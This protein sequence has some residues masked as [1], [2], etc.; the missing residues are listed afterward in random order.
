MSVTKL[1]FLFLTVS[2]GMTSLLL[3]QQLPQQSAS[4][5]PAIVDND[6]VQKE[7]GINCSQ[8]GAALTGDLDDD[9][10]EDVVI[11]AR[12]TSPMV[13]Q[14]EHDFKVVDP[15]YSFFGYGNPKVTTEFAAE[16]PERRAYVL[17]VIHGV[18]KDAWRSATPKAKFMVVNLPYRSISVKKLQ[19][20]KKQLMA[21]Y[22]EETG[23][24]QMT[25]VIFWDG[26]RYK[27]E[28]LGSSLDE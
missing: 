27:Y 10:V 23:A 19:V 7:F 22:V 17:L 5:L 26:R 16:H 8:V 24:D 25:S 1:A 18:G 3:G 14:A 11:P 4:A 15:Y 12:C 20:H 9:G 13:D 2:L 6:F 21:I 28:P